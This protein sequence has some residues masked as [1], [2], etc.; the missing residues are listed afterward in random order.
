[1]EGRVRDHGKLPGVPAN[2]YLNYYLQAKEFVEHSD[3][4]HTRAN[5][6]EETREKNLFDG[7]DHYLK[8]GEV[9]ANTFYAGSHGDWIADLPL[10]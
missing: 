4:N 7:I 3:P 8:T 10:R 5:E 9:D 1:M 6:V 2:T